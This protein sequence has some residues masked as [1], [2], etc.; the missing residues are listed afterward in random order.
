MVTTQALVE[1]PT[2]IWYVERERKAEKGA[3]RWSER[4][5]KIYFSLF[6]NF[7]V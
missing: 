3:E 2:N 5:K 1:D 6:F 4:L 7:L